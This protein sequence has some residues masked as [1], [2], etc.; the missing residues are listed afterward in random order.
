MTL[1]REE[2]EIHALGLVSPSLGLA[3]AGGRAPVQCRTDLRRVG[4]GP[5]PCVTVPTALMTDTTDVADEDGTQP[6]I[7]TNPAIASTAA[8]D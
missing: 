8:T 3:G 2:D 1:R 5:R 6:A 4:P 7:V